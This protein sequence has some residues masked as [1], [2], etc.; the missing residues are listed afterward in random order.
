MAKKSGITKPEKKEKPVKNAKT[1]SNKFNLM[2]RGKES[3]KR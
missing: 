2:I 1:K 3:K